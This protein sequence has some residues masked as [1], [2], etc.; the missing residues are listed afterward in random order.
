MAIIIT[1]LYVT[2]YL[3]IWDINFL[4]SILN[5][6]VPMEAHY[7]LSYIS[8]CLLPL[9][10]RTMPCHIIVRPTS[11]PATSNQYPATSNQH[12]VPRTALSGFLPTIFKTNLP[13]CPI[14]YFFYNL[15]AKTKIYFLPG[16]QKHHSKAS[17]IPELCISSQWG[18]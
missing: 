3:F 17:A 9:I 1:S 5:T 8:Y 7:I 2:F 15:K 18:N 4:Q 10:G 13:A 14:T 11:K 12:P 6:L 16:P